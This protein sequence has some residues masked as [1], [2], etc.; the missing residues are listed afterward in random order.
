[1]HQL[2]ARMVGEGLVGAGA[3]GGTVLLSPVLRPWYSGWGVSAVERLRPLPG[4]HYVPHPK[5]AMTCA[6]TIAAPPAVIWPW[7]VQLGCRR[8]GWYSYDLLDNGGQPSADRILPEYQ[9]LAIGDVVSAVPDGSFGFPVAE[10]VPERAL[11]LAGTLDT[12]TG[13]PAP[14]DALPAAYF[15]GAMVWVLEPVGPHATRLTYRMRTDWNASALNTVIY[16]GLLEPISF[17]MCRRMLINLKRR[18]ERAAP[19]GRP[20]S[21]LPIV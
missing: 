7:F 2:S 5:S 18:C 20:T 12:T 9:Q 19:E 11:V 4:D 6:V 8:G 10:I 1:M 16:R 14:P 3:V 13:Q 21:A 15:S 17:V